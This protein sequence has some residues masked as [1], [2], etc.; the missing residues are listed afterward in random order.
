MS[1]YPDSPAGL[2]A[3]SVVIAAFMMERWNDL[4]EAVASVRAQP[5]GTWVYEPAAVAGH[6]VPLTRATLRFFL[7]RCFNEGTGKVA[8]AALNG[9]GVSTSAER[10]YAR[11]VLPRGFARGL[12]D[13]AHGHGSEGLR[14]LAIAAGLSAATAGFMAGQAAAVI[15]AG[16]SRRRGPAAGLRPAPGEA[17]ATAAD[18]R[19]SPLGV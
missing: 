17:G 15:R 5:G 3:V 16:G 8:P 14:S 2:P 1:D 11:R 9:R 19:N 6:R 18:A 7:R 10:E 12:R 4:F 13:A